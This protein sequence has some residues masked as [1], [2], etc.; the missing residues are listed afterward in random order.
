MAN[1]GYEATNILHTCPIQNHLP[2]LFP[3]NNDVVLFCKTPFYTFAFFFCIF[4]KFWMGYL[5][6]FKVSHIVR[7]QEGAISG[8]IPRNYLCVFEST[9]LDSV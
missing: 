6:I 8:I 9:C 2:V 4:F 7:C 3:M 1:F 5:V